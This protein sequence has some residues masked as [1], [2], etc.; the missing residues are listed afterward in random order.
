MFQ[1]AY[2]VLYYVIAFRWL[3][4][5]L[6]LCL[7]CDSRDKTFPHLCPILFSTIDEFTSISMP[8]RMIHYSLE[9]L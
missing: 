5:Y 7:V 8:E 1:E 4:Y 3:L 9:N 2:L 6:E